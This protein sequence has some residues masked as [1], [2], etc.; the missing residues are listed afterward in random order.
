[1]VLF[2]PKPPRQIQFREIDV[3]RGKIRRNPSQRLRE[4]FPFSQVGNIGETVICQMNG[5]TTLRQ[6]KIDR[7]AAKQVEAAAHSG[8]EKVLT[9][10]NLI[11][12]R[13]VEFHRDSFLT[14]RKR[15]KR[16]LHSLPILLQVLLMG[17]LY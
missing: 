17:L 8:D 15:K 1:H 16:P 12:Y 6:F 9:L 2:L 5:V 3:T 4:E 11:Q 13:Q 10:R 14:T 7:Q